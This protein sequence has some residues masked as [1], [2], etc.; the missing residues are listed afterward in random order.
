MTLIV[1]CKGDVKS[2][3]G[4]QT[5]NVGQSWAL[6]DAGKD[7]GAEVAGGSRDCHYEGI[8]SVLISIQ[9]SHP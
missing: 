6:S 4:R 1:L 5:G 7:N 9:T 3:T 2:V 8:N